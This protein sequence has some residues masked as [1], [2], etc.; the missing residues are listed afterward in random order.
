MRLAHPGR[1]IVLAKLDA[2]RA[3]RQVPVPIRQFR[4]MAHRLNG[5]TG[6]EH[7]GGHGCSGIW[8]LDGPHPSTMLA[9]WIVQNL[10]PLYAT[11][12]ID[13]MMLIM[14]EDEAQA[15]MAQV[16]GLL[17]GQRLDGP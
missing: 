5:R 4:V 16:V 15:I 10:L 1:R 3:F 6:G 14:Y 11:S 7:K 13:D 2:V 17:I 12:Y 9:D 8:R